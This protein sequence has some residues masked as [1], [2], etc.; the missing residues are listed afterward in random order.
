MCIICNNLIDPESIIFL[1]C[2]KCPNV[3]T[4]PENLPNVKFLAIY[5]TNI[6]VIQSYPS[7]EGLYC[8]NCPIETLPD[9][10]KLRKLN[11]TGSALKEIP[12]TLYRLEVLLVNNT[13]ITNIPDT[14]ISAITISANNTQISQIS[15]KLINVE[16]LSI[17]GTQV[18]SLE[19]MMS[20]QYLDCS[21]TAITDIPVDM[22]T[23]LRKVFAR[24]CNITDPFN[25]IQKG[26]DMTN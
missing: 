6:S 19:P 3:S 25:I 11:A 20:L 21:N 16:S 26:I 8:M 2:S 10:P 5:D 15:S 1:D 17:S 24:G 7:L 13:K 4:L 18:Q 9:L 22:I 23:G 14:L 12:G